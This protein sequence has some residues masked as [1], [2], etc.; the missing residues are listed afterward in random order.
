MA[1]T[2]TNALFVVLLNEVTLKAE[3]SVIPA[4]CGSLKKH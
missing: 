3:R 1:W 4:V 2:G